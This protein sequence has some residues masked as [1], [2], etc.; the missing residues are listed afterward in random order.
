MDSTQKTFTFIA[1]AIGALI[2]I[3]LLFV[4]GAWIQKKLMTWVGREFLKLTISGSLLNLLLVACIPIAVFS[5]LLDAA[6]L[7]GISLAAL[8]LGYAPVLWHYARA[9]PIGFDIERQFT[10]KEASILS[11]GSTLAVATI[12][13][14]AFVILQFL[15]ASALLGGLVFLRA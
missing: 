12:W 7:T 8:F 2:I 1:I 5:A 6:G 13:V 11:A 3:L 10:W 4:L 14:V 15:G 9:V